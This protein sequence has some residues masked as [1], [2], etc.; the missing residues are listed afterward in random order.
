MKKNQSRG[1]FTYR[2]KKLGLYVNILILVCFLFLVL[3]AFKAVSIYA[4][5][6]VFIIVLIYLL[7]VFLSRSVTQMVI[8]DDERILFIDVKKMFLKSDR[9]AIN[10]DKLSQ[11]FS[12]E[13]RSRGHQISVLRIYESN[14]EVIK[15]IPSYSNWNTTQLKE[16]SSIL[17]SLG[18]P[19]KN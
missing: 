17:T 10:Y 13:I 3:F 18:V 9:I 12:K 1:I 2:P 8:N 15:I 16:I 19:F 14:Q 5:S 11:S 7:N 6:F 4:A